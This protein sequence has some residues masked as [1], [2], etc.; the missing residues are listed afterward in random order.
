MN[1]F[2]QSILK[3]FLPSH[4]LI[5]INH[6]LYPKQQMV[7]F[8]FFL[9]NRLHSEFRWDIEWSTT[10]NSRPDT[11]CTWPSSKLG[12]PSTL[13]E[14]M[15]PLLCFPVYLHQEAY[16]LNILDRPRNPFIDKSIT[17]DILKLSLM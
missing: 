12:P 2:L 1:F 3:M 7:S 9:L 13:T 17:L 5:P 11:Y 16:L 4:P 10:G 8:I 14:H 15:S 6:T